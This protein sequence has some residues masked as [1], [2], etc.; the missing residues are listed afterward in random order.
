MLLLLV[1]EIIKAKSINEKGKEN[2]FNS[3]IDHINEIITW[4]RIKAVNDKKQFNDQN[5]QKHFDIIKLSIELLTRSGLYEKSF[6][7]K[8]IAS[9]VK[10]YQP[11][12]NDVFKIYSLDEYIDFVSFILDLERMIVLN[13]LNQS[14][15]KQITTQVNHIFLVDKSEDILNSFYWG[16]IG[17]R[18]ANANAQRLLVSKYDLMNKIRLLAQPI[19]LEDKLNQAFSQYIIKVSDKIYESYGNN[20]FELFSHFSSLKKNIDSFTQIGFGNN[21]K[22]K[23]TGKDSLSKAFN[24]KPNYIA[25]LLSRY[26]DLILISSP[27]PSSGKEEES[28]DEENED[29][30]KKQI[31]DFMNLFKLLEAKDSFEKYYIQKLLYRCLYHSSTKREREL[32]MIDQFKKECGANFV[33]KS[34]EILNDFSVSNELTN[35]YSDIINLEPNPYRFYILSYYSWPFT[36]ILNGFVNKDIEEMES[37]FSDFY[38]QKNQG[39]ILNWVLPFCHCELCFKLN[40][41]LYSIKGN[42]VHASVLLKYTLKTKRLTIS[43]LVKSTK[44]EGNSLLSCLKPIV[45]I[46]LLVY[47]SDEDSYAFNDKFASSNPEIRLIG[48]KK[49]EASM[50]EMDIT[51]EKTFEERKPVIDCYIIKILKAKKQM[52]IDDLINSVH[53]SLIFPCERQMIKARIDYLLKADMIFKDEIN[54]GIIKYS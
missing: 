29:K 18:N 6:N 39:R 49:S 51:E 48:M 35:E 21:E 3:I 16:E 22:V 24:I 25:E 52:K 38:K 8:F 15:L 53:H 7:G 26:I 32:L 45:D 43:E 34:E 17:N 10:F 47:N 1:I 11:L 14:S 20:C 37:V 30:V 46:G 54:E 27:L 28:K 23:T 41:N 5:R 13:H 33:S 4:F 9:S 31:E 40:N 44:I 42:G 19:G 2:I 50:I 12:A 36:N